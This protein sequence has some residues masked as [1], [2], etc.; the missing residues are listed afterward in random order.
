MQPLSE[1]TRS[2][3]QALSGG[4]IPAFVTATD[5]AEAAQ[6]F[7]V[8]RNNVAHSLR[9]ALGRRFPVVK[10]LVGTTFFDAMATEFIARHPPQSPVLQEW[11]EAFA[12]FLEGFPPVATL[13]YLPDVARIEWAR[14]RAYHAADLTPLPADQLQEDHPLILHPSVQVLHSHHPAVSIW[15]ANQPAR[16]GKLRAGGAE[17]ALIRRK[18]DFEVPVMAL[19]PTDAAFIDVL[20]QGKPL[21]VAAIITD[22]VP[23]LSL[24]LKDGLIC[25]KES[26]Q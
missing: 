21:G 3:R 8:Y 1:L 22:P 10:R 6:R 7:A 20:L 23:M 26:I 12:P 25:K 14:G 24:L 17:Y 16:D 9:Q 15:H 4:D 5:P 18:P 19:S 2:F 11:G 13:P